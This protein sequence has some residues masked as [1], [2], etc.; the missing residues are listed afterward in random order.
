MKVLGIRFCTATPKAEETATCL[1]K[2]GLEEMSL[3]GVEGLPETGF[4]GAIFPA[5]D[6]RSWVEIWPEGPEM[7]EGT[8]LQIIVDD[9]EAYAKHARENGL[10]PQGPMDAH[11]ERIYFLTTPAGL[12]VSFQSALPKS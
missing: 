9:A 1:R 8:M 2:L 4:S 11:G 3:D 7:P 10:D 12:Q 5:E 6:S